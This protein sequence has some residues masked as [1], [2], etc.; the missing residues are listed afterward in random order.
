MVK[1][2]D[3]EG[4]NVSPVLILLYWPSWIGILLFITLSNPNL[5]LLLSL[6]L[7]F[8]LPL[9]LSFHLSL[10]LI[11]KIG[12]VLPLVDYSLLYHHANPK[13]IILVKMF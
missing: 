13:M 9:T 3:R 5:P 4:D 10:S 11:G 6:S 1:S 12:L 7:S 2:V 8:H